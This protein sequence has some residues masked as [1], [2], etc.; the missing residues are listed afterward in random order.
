MTE[1]FLKVLSMSLSALWLVGIVLLLRLAL[2]RSPKWIHVL[3]WAMVA[4]RLVCPFSL[5]SSLSLIPESV[6]SG[7]VLE[8][9]SD[10]YV[11]DVEIIHDIRPEYQTA[12]E[13]GREPVSAGEDGYY[14]VTG[15]DK[16][17]EPETVKT[18]VLPRLALVWVAGMAVMAL[19]TAVS[20]LSLCQKMST[21][22]RMKGNIYRSEAA[23]SPFVLGLI[24]PRIYLP[25]AMDELDIPHV[26]AH[27]RAHIRRKDH[28]WKP[29]GFLVLTL[30]WFNPAVWLSYCL[31][32]RDIELACDEKVI[33]DM[34]PQQQADYSQ[35]LLNCSI[36]R[37]AIAACPL[38]FGEVGVKKRVS[39]ILNYRK[40]AFWIVLVALVLCALVA[41]CFLTNP[42][43][44]EK[45]FGTEWY[46]DRF[47]YTNSTFSTDR[48]APLTPE[49]SGELAGSAE[50]RMIPYDAFLLR[51]IR[52]SK[53]GEAEIMNAANVAQWNPL[54]TFREAHLSMLNFDEYFKNDDVWLTTLY[55]PEKFRETCTRA[56]RLDVNPDGPGLFYLLLELEDGRFYLMCGY[57]GN[58]SHP[59]Q[60][61]LSTM[62]WVVRLSDTPPLNTAL[63][64]FDYLETGAYPSE[65]DDNQ[66]KIPHFPGVTFRADPGA[67]YAETEEGST[68]IIT[69]MPVWNVYFCD[70]TG[71][72]IY[73]LCATVSEGSGIIDEHI[74]VYDYAA[75]TE[76]TLWDRGVFDYT[77]R[78][79][80]HQL[81]CDKRVYPHAEILES[82]PLMLV[83][84]G[85]GD[86]MRLEIHSGDT[87]EKDPSSV[88]FA[89]F[90][91]SSVTDIKLDNAHNG[92]STAISDP[93]AVK[94]IC[95]W[96]SNISGSNGRN[97]KGWHYQGSFALTLLAE[98]QEVFQIVFGDDDVFFY[99]MYDQNY[100]V[101]YDLDRDMED[102]IRFLHRYDES[103]FDW[104]YEETVAVAETTP[105]DITS[106]IP[107]DGLKG[108]IEYL[109]PG[110]IIGYGFLKAELQ[111]L[112]ILLNNLT[113]DAFE[114][115][116]D[117][118]PTMKIN[119]RWDGGRMTLYSDGKQTVFGEDG[120]W[121]VCTKE[122]NKFLSLF[123]Q[124]RLAGGEQLPLDELSP[125]YNTEQAMIDGCV[126]MRDGD[127]Q[128]GQDLF[129][130]FS[131]T[132]MV[133]KPAQIRI[134]YF[135]S[136]EGFA[137]QVS[138]ILY[139]GE[140]FT[141]QSIE[142]GQLYERNYQYLYHYNGEPKEITA[143]YD[144]F[145]AYVLTDEEN[146]TW[147]ELWDSLASSQA[148]VAIDFTLVFMDYIYYI[149]NPVIPQCETVTL[150]FD[151]KVLLTVEDTQ[152]LKALFSRANETY[153]PKT[154]SP[155]P[156]L[157]FAGNDG[158]EVI[159]E[160][161]LD[162]DWVRIDGIYY[163]FGPGFDEDGAYDALAYLFSLLGIR[164]WP[165]EV[166]DGLEAQWAAHDN[167]DLLAEYDSLIADSFT[168]GYV[169]YSDGTS[170]ELR[171][172]DI[173]AIQDAMRRAEVSD[174]SDFPTDE[175]GILETGLDYKI[176]LTRADGETM[177]LYCWE[178]DFVS[179]LD[180]GRML[181]QVVNPGLTEAISTAVENIQ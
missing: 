76:Y 141:L 58:E 46:L 152:A 134:A 158:T 112:G 16:I 179:L 41:V 169:L 126:V 54:G 167:T 96:L 30:H 137:L 109:Q 43:G 10:G 31:L 172:Q 99:G 68:R 159:V 104:G 128:S 105:Y 125:Y 160:L 56:W 42:P 122:L 27:E 157:R 119:L 6:S 25:F 74:V 5:E 103:G 36:H 114:A 64:W 106:T 124:E 144:N 129:Y 69:G 181:C 132:V 156:I 47:L 84:A 136:N 7:A 100:A 146:V 83:S 53:N 63:Q 37:R 97:S 61:P 161:G 19:Y 108:D 4:F 155:G 118:T 33:R 154:W 73:E 120:E 75:G 163:D 66:A 81:V 18:E 34:N 170:K 48:F 117:Y 162:T 111:E 177:V 8:E 123:T 175:N 173:P 23:A 143:T 139:D 168:A 52:L 142:D 2:K 35:A 116:A 98:N 85:G 148:G 3:L 180:T 121:A 17:S 145:N 101:M 153:E 131:E 113:E 102:V 164:D 87:K 20:Y 95:T 39:N 130:D 80:D 178:E 86:G 165:Q 92:R 59:G 88:S 28:W 32:C 67:V 150:E 166:Y 94:S 133:G 49:D 171:L 14:V 51:G 29:L 174:G 57:D 151:G 40:S 110:D 138:D 12:V 93:D 13:A 149:N 140:D 15:P 44:A 65:D 89:N 45:P 90:D 11:G 70:L 78:L 60:D 26:I 1:L 21:A 135:S 115:P 72:G 176:A 50:P 127:A 22:V 91:F 77:L 147:D 82:G 55:R 62:L 38:A 71:D 107:E 79:Q 9:W 24:H